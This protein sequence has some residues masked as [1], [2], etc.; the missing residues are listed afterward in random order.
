M[1]DAVIINRDGR[2]Q[3][4][5]GVID[6]VECMAASANL[7]NL[8]KGA[9]DTL[10][11]HYP[12]WLWQIRPNEHGGIIDIFSLKLSGRLAYTLHIPTVQEDE[13]FRCIVRAG[14]ELLERFGFR[15][16]GYS[17]DEWRRREMVLGQFIPNAEDLPAAA[18]RSMHTESLKQ[19]ISTGHARVAVN[20]CIGAAL[21]AA[22]RL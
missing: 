21:R 20:P 2:F 9:G 8:V 22:G 5:P 1:S 17:Y 16:V 6:N 19:A 13:D 7:L 12:G 4:V 11:R 14:G 3:R 18:R 15:R 10:E